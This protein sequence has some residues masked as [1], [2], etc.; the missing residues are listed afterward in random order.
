MEVFP[1]CCDLYKEYKQCLYL[2]NFCG[3][4]D[5]ESI[6]ENSWLLYESCKYSAALV[7]QI[8]HLTMKLF[9]ALN[10][11]GVRVLQ[12][13]WILFT[14]RLLENINYVVWSDCFLVFLKWKHFLLF[15]VNGY[16]GPLD[17][18]YWKIL[19]QSGSLAIEIEGLKSCI[20]ASTVQGFYIQFWKWL[21]S[22]ENSI[23]KYRMGNLKLTSLNSIHIIPFT[24]LHGT[25]YVWT[26]AYIYS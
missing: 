14:L 18:T 25:V 19:S 2:E 26:C 13:S 7:L 6:S 9:H 1:C 12:M 3:G 17:T 11:N 20:K 4:Y 23:F 16:F 22:K 8:L 24:I 5:P 15:W 10:Y 21:P